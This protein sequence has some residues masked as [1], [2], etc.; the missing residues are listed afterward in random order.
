MSV[1]LRR[2]RLSVAHARMDRSVKDIAWLAGII[3]GE[4]WFCM[5]N[6]SPTLGLNMSDFDVV[7]RAADI[8][9]AKT[10]T[11]N[12]GRRAGYKRQLRITVC[13]SQAA[14]WC[15]TLYPLMGVR[16]RAKM[17]EV[18]AAWKTTRLYGTP[19][20]ACEHTDR[21]HYAKGRCKLCHLKAWYSANRVAVNAK[22]RAARRAARQ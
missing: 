14:A 22:L 8:M 13:G 7:H 15:M 9:G 11:D 19:I 2:P 4:G 21:P 18:I 17:R 1:P 3:E 20:T 10:R 6:N 16:R 5:Q 12:P